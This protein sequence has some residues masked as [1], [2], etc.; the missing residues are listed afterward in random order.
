MPGGS[1]GVSLP[2]L[3][4]RKSDT[5]FQSGYILLCVYRDTHLILMDPRVAANN[6]EDILL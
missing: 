5:H 2:G 6:G 3:T 4:I 1:E